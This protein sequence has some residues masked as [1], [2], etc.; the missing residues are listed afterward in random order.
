MEREIHDV[1]SLISS[2][3]ANMSALY[4]KWT[5]MKSDGSNDRELQFVEELI[6][7]DRKEILVLQ[8]QLNILLQRSFADLRVEEPSD[9]SS[10]GS[11]V[12]AFSQR[13]PASTSKLMN[14]Q[15]SAGTNPHHLN[16]SSSHML[17]A[18]SSDN[19]M[20]GRHSSSKNAGTTT[21]LFYSSDEHSF[22][23][24]HRLRSKLYKQRLIRR[25]ARLGIA[26]EDVPAN[27][28]VPTNIIRAAIFASICAGDRE[29]FLSDWENY[30]YDEDV[31]K[32][33]SGD[34]DF[35]NNNNSDH[36][37]TSNVNN[38]DQHNHRLSSAH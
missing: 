7:S 27:I 9:D 12:R 24:E 11:Q 28:W 19:I 30:Q 23:N 16:A 26:E 18:D 4:D 21:E 25:L 36:D 10:N 35:D 31:D 32:D 34:S 8:K 1:R 2:L 6:M 13:S 38:N 37:S 3:R 33:W 29:R 17:S 20:H 5:Q 15:S 22:N 14:R